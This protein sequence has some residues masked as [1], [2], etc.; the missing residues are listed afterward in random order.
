MDPLVPA[1]LTVLLAETGSKTQ[2][3]A[4]AHGLA[5][6]VVP[7][8]C[9]LILVSIASFA[10][11]ASAGVFIGARLPLE[12]RGLLFAVALLATGAHMLTAPR[13]TPAMNAD[14]NFGSSLWGFAKSQFGDDAQFLVFAL[15]A[16]SGLPMF[17]ACGGLTGIVVACLIPMA[18]GRDWPVMRLR[19]AR[20]GI[21]AILMLAGFL[22]GI[23]ILGL[24]TS[25]Q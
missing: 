12:A 20:R 24:S 19:W 18:A 4:H 22:S 21:A 3:F 8:L 16:K 25:F 13:A 6:R 23:S 15:A 14:Q 7:G 17:A 2:A 1:F 10:I 11:A 5:K 9:A